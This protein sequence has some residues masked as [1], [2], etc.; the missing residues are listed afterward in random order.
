MCGLVFK[1]LLNNGGIK[2]QEKRNLEKAKYLYDYLDNSL[3]YKTLADKNSR[4]IMN[5]VFTTGNKELDLLFVEE[6]KKYGDSVMIGDAE[7]TWAEMISDYSKGK[8]KKVYQK[9]LTELDKRSGVNPFEYNIENYQG[10][11]GYTRT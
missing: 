6:A 4:S 2:E 10:A 8:L 3:F 5:V 1:Y 7:E 9:K 11:G